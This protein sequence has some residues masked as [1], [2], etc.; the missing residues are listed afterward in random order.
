L[1]GSDTNIGLETSDRQRIF[2]VVWSGKSSSQV[3]LWRVVNFKA[4]V[5]EIPEEV[6]CA[7]SVGMRWVIMASLLRGSWC[8]RCLLA[9]VVV[10]LA[11]GL[12]LGQQQRSL[13]VVG[14]LW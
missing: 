12:H 9:G 1:G 5:L 2:E 14:W 13:V 8:R 6:S 10:D 7:Y 11:V 4:V 3:G